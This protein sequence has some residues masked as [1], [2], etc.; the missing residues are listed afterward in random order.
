LRLG[1]KEQG[2]KLYSTQVVLPKN[3]S[4]RFTKPYI[5]PKTGKKVNYNRLVFGLEKDGIHCIIW[6]DGPD[7]QEK[8]MRF[9]GNLANVISESKIKTGGYSAE[10][11]YY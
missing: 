10:I 8:L 2:G 5:N 4:Q 9:K 1:W 7:K 11:T 6:L 3:F